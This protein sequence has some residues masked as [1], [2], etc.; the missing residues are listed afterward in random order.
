MKEQGF[1]SPPKS[2]LSVCL[3]A[4]SKIGM[5]ERAFIIMKLILCFGQSPEP[6]VIPSCDYK[7]C[8]SIHMQFMFHPSQR[9]VTLLFS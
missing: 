2:S 3:S 6:R 5:E 4:C 9:T 8:M 7:L 1:F